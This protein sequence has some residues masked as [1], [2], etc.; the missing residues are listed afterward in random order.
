MGGQPAGTTWLRPPPAPVIH[1]AGA[2]A[3]VAIPSSGPIVRAPRWRRAI[4]RLLLLSA[5]LRHR[6][7]PRRLLENRLPTS[8]RLISAKARLETVLRCFLRRWYLLP[9]PCPRSL[10]QFPG[11]PRAVHMITL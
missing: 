7:S 10:P 11:L 6:T 1:W 4:Q 5:A 2:T 3:S 8:V 9:L